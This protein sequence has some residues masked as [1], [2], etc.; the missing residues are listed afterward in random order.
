MISCTQDGEVVFTADETSE[1]VGA[2]RDLFDHGDRADV[3]KE[4]LQKGVRG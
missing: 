3:Q 2:L 1:L 4:L